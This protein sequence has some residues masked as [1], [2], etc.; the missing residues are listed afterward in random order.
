M[1][2][3]LAILQDSGRVA[4]VISHVY[5]STG[6]GTKELSEDLKKRCIKLYTKC[7]SN[8]LK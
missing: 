3:Y 8:L 4:D 1:Y 5:N 6:E 2:L 7:F